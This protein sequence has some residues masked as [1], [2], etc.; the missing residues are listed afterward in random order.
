MKLSFCNYTDTSYIDFGI[1]YKLASTEVDDGECTEI[2]AADIMDYVSHSDLQLFLNMIIKKLRHNGTIVLG[3]S[4]AYETCKQFLRGD[5]DVVEL[6]RK[7]YGDN[8][9]KNGHWT[10]NVLTEALVNYGLKI[11]EKNID[12]NKMYIKAQRP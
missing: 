10:L 4:D 11:L 5:F 12:G 8:L 2:Y 9:F 7:L 3:G 6:N 1:N